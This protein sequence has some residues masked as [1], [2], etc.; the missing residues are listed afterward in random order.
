[1]SL[2]VLNGSIA[3]CRRIDALDL[4]V[5]ARSANSVTAR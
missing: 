3:E 2:V 1:M 4:F 5:T